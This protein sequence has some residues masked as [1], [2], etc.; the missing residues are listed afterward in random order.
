M[1]TYLYD[2][3]T[4][5]YPAPWPQCRS[6]RCCQQVCTA[7]NIYTSPP[8]FARRNHGVWWRQTDETQKVN[9]FCVRETSV[10]YTPPALHWYFIVNVFLHTS[11]LFLQQ[12]Y[13]VQKSTL[14]LSLILSLL[15]TSAL[16]QGLFP[17]L[18]SPLNFALSEPAV[19]TSTC[20]GCEEGEEE[21][22]TL[23]NNTCPFGDDFPAPHDLLATGTLQPGVVSVLSSYTIPPFLS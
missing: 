20:G 10:Q 16:P 19:A 9:K 4:T 15:V 21:G 11:V 5:V 18:F 3:M 13:P 22:C 8:V 6:G 12:M 1:R 17:P 23:C 14:L 2:V 7:G